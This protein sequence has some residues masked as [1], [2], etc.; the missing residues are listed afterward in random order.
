MPGPAGID[1]FKV[2][3]PSAPAAEPGDTPGRAM[4]AALTDLVD[5]SQATMEAFAAKQA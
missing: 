1:L 3:P 2:L 4:A 5:R